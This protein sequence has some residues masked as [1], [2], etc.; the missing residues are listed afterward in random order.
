MAR[1]ICLHFLQVFY[2]SPREKGLGYWM[3]TP[4]RAGLF[5]LFS[6][7][8]TGQGVLKYKRLH[9]WKGDAMF[10]HNMNN[11]TGF[12]CTFVDIYKEV[13]RQSSSPQG[14]GKFEGHTC[15]EEY[16]RS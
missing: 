4:P 15:M 1:G 14:L 13:A 6:M 3:Q 16:R 8:L 9:I 7:L 10:D 12:F 11:K 5:P 2:R